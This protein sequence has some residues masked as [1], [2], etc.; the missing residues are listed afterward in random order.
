MTNTKV[1]LIYTGGTIGMVEDQETRALKP[2]DF[3]HI[4]EE[5]PE[6][7][8]FDCQIESI[9]FEKPIDSSDMTPEIWVQLAEL[10]ES[11]YEEYDGFVVLHGSDTMAYTASALSFML[12]NL[13][14]PVVFTGSQLPIGIIRTDG[15]ENL[16]T[17]VEIAAA[18]DKN[19]EPIV[20]E[21][22]IYF[23]YQLYRANRTTK[24]NSEDFEAFESFNYGKLAE[25]GIHIKYKRYNIRSKPEGPLTLHKL[26]D[27]NIAV[28]K[29]FPG[30][31]KGQI[32]HFFE[33]PNL[34][35]AI[36]ETFGSGNATTEKWFIDLVKA[37]VEKGIIVINVTQCKGGRVE[38]EAYQAGKGMSSIGVIGAADMTIEAT[39]TKM[40]IL[41]GEIENKEKV[42]SKILEPICGE[43][44]PAAS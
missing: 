20:P 26:F 3:Q 37:A 42:K 15:K 1:L 40:M 2:F 30:I 9:S 34:K 32:A 39:I 14:K 5:V 29:L 35:C 18:K 25:A 43:I 31:S 11:N 10:I 19:K 22:S 24:I 27:N 36:L 13:A 17:A 6:L 8:K 4:K 23:E 33:V 21:V 16:I 28:L 12:E 41:L 38:Q 44:T 7:K